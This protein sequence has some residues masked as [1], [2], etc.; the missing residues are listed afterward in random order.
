M[1]TV[2]TVVFSAGT[3]WSYAVSGPSCN[4]HESTVYRRVKRKTIVKWT[5]GSTSE[6]TGLTWAELRWQSRKS[7]AT[8]SSVMMNTP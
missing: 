3:L 1:H 8:L 6:Q 2:I 4:C 7:C 5:T